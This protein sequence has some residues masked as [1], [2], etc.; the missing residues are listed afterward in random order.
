[1]ATNDSSLDTVLIAMVIA[2]KFSSRRCAVIV[3]SSS[4]VVAPGRR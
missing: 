2:C 1:M 3:I 4:A